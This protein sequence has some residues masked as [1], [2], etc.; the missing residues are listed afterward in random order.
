MRKPAFHGDGGT[1][2]GIELKN[3]LFS[4]LTLGIYSFWGRTEVRK[5]IWSQ[6]Q[7]EGDRFA[8]HGTG[9]ELLRGWLKA[10]GLIF[11]PAIVAF[12]ALAMLLGQQGRP[13]VTLLFYMGLGIL[14]P[15]AMVGARRYRMSRTSWRGIRFS[16]RGRAK[17]FIGIFTGGWL[18]NIVTLGLYYPFY[19]TRKRKFF[20]ENTYFGAKSFRFDGTAQE[21]YGT[22]I[23]TWLLMLPTLGLYWFWFVAK[24]ESYFWA[25]TAFDAARFRSTV[26]GG[27]LLGLAVTNVLLV[28]FTLNLGA[29]WVRVRT[30]RFMFDRLQLA[31]PLDLAAIQQEAQAASATSEGLTE[32]LN[33]EALDVDLGV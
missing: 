23:V 14:I 7:F 22:F 20:V 24:R 30:L 15:V 17:D 1:L 25:H 18:L 27:Q 6:T 13:F 8:Y 4:I 10:M 32:V 16:F 28:I 11:L 19:E 3:L 26:T 9:G 31:G 33:V 5:Y 29:A 2:F 12:M 21:I